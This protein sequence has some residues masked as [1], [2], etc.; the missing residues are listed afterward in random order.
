MN[1]TPVYVEHVGKEATEVVLVLSVSR[2]AVVGR[3][4]VGRLAVHGASEA[5]RAAGV[6]TVGAGFE[7]REV[8]RPEERLL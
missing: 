1:L 4:L 2:E 8:E 7:V 3:D 5:L 6:R